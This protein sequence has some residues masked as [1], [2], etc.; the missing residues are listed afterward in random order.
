M[1]SVWSDCSASLVYNGSLP[2]GLCSAPRFLIENTDGCLHD[3]SR[4]ADNSAAGQQVGLALLATSPLLHSVSCKH[5]FGMH[6]HGKVS[7]RFS[8]TPC[9]LAVE[10]HGVHGAI[11]VSQAPPPHSTCSTRTHAAHSNG[12]IRPPAASLPAW[13]LQERSACH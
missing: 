7:R 11:E 10:L 6:S 4:K 3:G 1:N 9:G 2:E 13:N 8:L 12:S 5:A